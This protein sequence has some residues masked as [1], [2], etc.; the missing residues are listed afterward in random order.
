M[1][2][3]R[4]EKTLGFL[5]K[6]FEGFADRYRYEHSIRV[7]HVGAK[8]ARAEGLDE[9][10]LIIACLLHDIAY[11]AAQSEGYDWYEH[12]RDGAR[13]ARP[14]L[15]SLGMDASDIEE[16]CF[17]IA[18]HVDDKADFEGP[19]SILA[20]SV[21]DADNI[22]RFDMLRLYLSLYNAEIHNLSL[23]E[24]VDWL[25]NSIARLR[26]FKDFP[27]ATASGK[28]MWLDNIEYQLSFQSRL[29]AQLENST[30]PEDF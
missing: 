1:M 5:E 11:S 29:L 19:D 6:S 7:A 18:I 22:D 9:E 24:K 25:I 12:G 20:R 2:T 28:K 10:K 13:L 17:G 15:Q 8:I 16:I 26:Q 4:I 30:I 14:F 27:F 3:P 23:D 21:A